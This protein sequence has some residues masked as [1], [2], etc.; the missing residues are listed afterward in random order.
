MKKK[1]QKSDKNGQRMVKIE[2][3]GYWFLISGEREILG[4]NIFFRGLVNCLS[5]RALLT[6][7]T[8]LD[9]HKVTECIKAFNS[10]AAA[11]GSLLFFTFKTII[12]KHE[13]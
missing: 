2:N 13:K 9:L 10:S 1:L 6:H 11:S 12:E 8:P 5:I 7:A 4:V 3:I